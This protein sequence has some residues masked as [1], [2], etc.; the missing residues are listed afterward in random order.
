M[1]VVTFRADNQLIKKAREKAQKLGRSLSGQIRYLLT[2]FL[3]D[4]N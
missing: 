2:K 3:D 4:G 1:K